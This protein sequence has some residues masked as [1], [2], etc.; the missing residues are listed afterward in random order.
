M[1][2]ISAAVQIE[3]DTYGVPHIYA[4]TDA[5]AYFGLGYAEAQD[6]LFQME[7]ERRVG[8]G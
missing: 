7:M 4:K 8:E 6:R 3:R 5:D 2:G 1:R